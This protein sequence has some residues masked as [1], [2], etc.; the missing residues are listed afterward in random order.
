[1]Q[2]GLGAVDRAELAVDVV[3]VGAHRARRELELARDLLV[4]LALGQALEHLDLARGQRARIDLALAR[5]VPERQVVHHRAQL[6]GTEADARARP[7]S[8]SPGETAAPW[9]VVGEHVG[10]PDERGLVRRRRRRGGARSPRLASRAG[11]SGGRARRRP[12]RG[13]RRARGARGGCAPPACARRCGSAR[14]ARVG[15]QEHELA[16]VVQQ[17][18]DH[19]AVALRRSGPRHPGGRPRAGSP[20][21][22]G[23][24]ARARPPTASSARRSRTC[25]RARRAPGPPWARAPRR[26]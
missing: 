16:D 17:R 20:R 3:Q 14:V 23:G 8:S 5:R 2:D 15:V 9:R 4:D 11:P 25:A 6:V 10:E 1:M 18:C 22:A 21:R 26:P 13:R 19:Q 24:S 7:C 12:A